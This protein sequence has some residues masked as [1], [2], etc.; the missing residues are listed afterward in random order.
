MLVAVLLTLYSPRPARADFVACNQYD[1]DL[2]VSIG[3]Y[4]SVNSGWT[5]Q[6]H[7]LVNSN[8]CRNL[9][10]SDLNE[11]IY[12]YAQSSSTNK[13]HWENPGAPFCIDTREVYETVWDGDDN[14]PYYKDLEVSSPVFD[15]CT[16][17][18]SNYERVS[19][20][21]IEASASYDHCVVN[22]HDYDR[23][24]SYCWD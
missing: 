7:Y 19:F 13:T 4:S 12:F 16:N 1:N 17:L 2:N 20:Y 10:L 15:S 3:Y 22:L 6:G 14:I 9:Y 5:A 18:G 24:H 8:S 11:T 21:E 23:W